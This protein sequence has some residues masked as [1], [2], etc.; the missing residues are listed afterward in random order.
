[1][2][3]PLP[4]E[5]DFTQQWVHKTDGESVDDFVNSYWITDLDGEEEFADGDCDWDGYTDEHG[6]WY[7]ILGVTSNATYDEI[8]TAYREQIKLY[9]PDRVAALGPKLR[10]L[11]E[12]ETKALNAAYEEGL[13]ASR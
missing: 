11:A 1:M 4:G 2:D 9:H 10:E 8:K 6:H 5:N 13:R 3:R 7:E 12:Q